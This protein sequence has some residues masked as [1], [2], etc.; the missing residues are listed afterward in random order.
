LPSQIISNKDAS[1][2]PNQRYGDGAERVSNA[3]TQ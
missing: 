3:R 2:R 1:E